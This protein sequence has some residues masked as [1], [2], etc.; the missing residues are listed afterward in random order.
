M[1]Y[2][3]WGTKLVSMLQT[4]AMQAARNSA[5]EIANRVMEHAKHIYL[6]QRIK[7]GPSNIIASF[8]YEER[9]ITTNSVIGYFVAGGSTAPYIIFVEKY[10]WTGVHIGHKEGYHF[11]EKGA[12]K[13]SPEVKDIVH[14][15]FRKVFGG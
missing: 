11:M 13:A 2:K 7:T 6:Q 14:K 4:G 5:K 10:G 12:N 1:E 8:T 15:H 3:G 9:K